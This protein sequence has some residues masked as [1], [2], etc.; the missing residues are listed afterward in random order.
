MF[1]IAGVSSIIS[2]SDALGVLWESVCPACIRAK[3]G[4]EGCL[5]HLLA[6]CPAGLG[7]RCE[8]LTVEQWLPLAFP[9]IWE[10]CV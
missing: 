9:A 6:A 1:G 5:E 8:E 2:Q 3:G 7:R 4:W 10:L